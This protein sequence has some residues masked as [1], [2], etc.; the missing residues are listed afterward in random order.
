MLVHPPTVLF[1]KS[2]VHSAQQTQPCPRV[3]HGL[4]WQPID[5][6]STSFHIHRLQRNHVLPPRPLGAVGPILYPSIAVIPKAMGLMSRRGRRPHFI[7]NQTLCF[8]PIRFMGAGRNPD[9]G[10]SGRANRGHTE[11]KSYRADLFTFSFSFELPFLSSSLVH[12]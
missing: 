8:H 3:L 6:L 1:S 11:G 10:I 7:T 5:L 9:F 4:V 12:R 2:H